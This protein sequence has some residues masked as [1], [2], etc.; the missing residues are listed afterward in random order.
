ML[1]VVNS[2]FQ[3]RENDQGLKAAVSPANLSVCGGEFQAELATECV[4]ERGG[5]GS[6]SIPPPLPPT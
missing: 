1:Y 3:I 6:F 2:F 4:E 5:V